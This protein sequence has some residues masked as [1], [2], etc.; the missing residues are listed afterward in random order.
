MLFIVTLAYRRPPAELEAHLDAHRRWLAT[1][2]RAGHFIAA[3][4]LEPKT[5]GLIVAHGESRE[6]IAAL[7]ADDPFVIH[8]LVDAHV[9]AC[10]PAMRHAEFPERWAGAVPSLA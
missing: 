10:T 8:A 1:H 7:L 3:G 6:A 4:P 5:G 2:M 9:L